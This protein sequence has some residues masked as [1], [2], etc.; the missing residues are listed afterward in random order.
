MKH[1]KKVVKL[2][3]GCKNPMGPFGFYFDSEEEAEYDIEERLR[4]GELDRVIYLYEDGTKRTVKH[5][6][7]SA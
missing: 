2:Y 5:H 1:D 7:W 6:A 3:V 4:W